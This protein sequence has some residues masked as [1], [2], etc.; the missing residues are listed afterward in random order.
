MVGAIWGGVVALDSRYQTTALAEEQQKDIKSLSR[1][2]EVKIIGDM[3]NEYDN[4]IWKLEDRNYCYELTACLTK[5]DA[6]TKERYR[7]LLEERKKV[8][9]KFTK[10]HEKGEDSE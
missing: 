6:D 10:L 8:E 3:I 4:Q 7:K 9:I 5:M 1:R 2:L